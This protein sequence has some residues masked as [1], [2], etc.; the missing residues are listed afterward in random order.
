MKSVGSRPPQEASVDLA[1]NG[2]APAR[3]TVQAELERILAGATFRSSPRLSRFLRYTVEHTLQGEGDQLKEY[4]VGLDVYDRSSSYDP[5]NDPVVRLEARRLR[6]KLREYY[7]DEG[8]R[9][10]I[11]IDVPKGSY[12]ATFSGTGAGL[13]QDITA[14]KDEAGPSKA[15]GLSTA[16]KV[17]ALLTFLLLIAAG[18]AIYLRGPYRQRPLP[19][20]GATPSIAVLPFLNISGDPEDEHLSDGLS[21]ELTSTL[22]RLAGLRVVARTSAFRFKGK[23]EDVRT[24]G[25]QL[26]VGFILQGSVQ[27]SGPRLRITTQLVRVSDGTDLWSET[28]DENARDAFVVEDEVT[29]AVAK[30]L[31]VRLLQVADQATVPHRR[32]D[33]EAHD[34]YLRGRYW[35]NRRTLPAH[36]KSIGYFNQALEKDPLYAQAYLGLADAYLVLGANDQAPDEVFPKARAAARQALQLDDTLTEAHGTLA[37]VTLFYDWDFKTAEQ[38]FQRAIALNANDSSTHQWYGLLLMTAGRFDAAAME[39]RR[40]Q[41]LDPLSLI[42]ALDLGQVYYYSGNYGATH[43][44]A[45]RTLAHDPD[46]AASHDLLGM[47][48][49]L[50]GQYREAI[51][52]FQRYLVLSGRDPDA[53]MRLGESYAAS[54]ERDKAQGILEELEKPATRSYSSPY[55]IAV[56]FARLG[57]RGQAFHWVEMAIQQHSSSCL[58]LGID[59]AFDGFR[60]DPLFRELLRKAHIPQLRSKRNM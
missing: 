23:A 10:P 21:D 31:Q 44:Q 52:E 55:N 27:R 4:R 33:P 12:A 15:S 11:R 16:R 42:L 29:R 51:A 18:T 1:A 60:S 56:I 36:W 41:Q 49:L 35:W 48:F 53:L 24:I 58:L 43:Q 6:I 13:Q 19:G 22:A 17:A 50:K 47:A 57:N 46:F 45:Q 38:E 20:A 8:K 37:A 54:G 26:N 30:V 39:F 59:P 28:Y 3:D 2:A 7:D 9:D 5:R 14:D 32:L 40:A 25:S 34:L